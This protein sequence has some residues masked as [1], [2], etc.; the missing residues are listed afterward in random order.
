MHESTLGPLSVSAKRGIDYY[1]RIRSRVHELRATGIEPKEIWANKHVADCMQ[2][3]WIEI[4]AQYDE[5]LPYQ[6]AGV[7]FREGSTGGDDI[8]FIYRD[9]A[10][11]EVAHETRKS[12]LAD[13]TQK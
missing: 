6:I 9:G 11:N 10:D 12:R 1:D 5:I 2:L 4:C 7:P 13:G 8:V 3:F